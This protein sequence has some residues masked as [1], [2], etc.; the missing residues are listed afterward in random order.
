MPF[1][2]MIRGIP[3]NFICAIIVLSIA[4]SILIDLIFVVEGTGKEAEGTM[5]PKKASTWN[6]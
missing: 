2:L 5:Q 3:W 4:L 6:S 1:D